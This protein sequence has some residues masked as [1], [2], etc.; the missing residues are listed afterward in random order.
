LLTVTSGATATGTTINGGGSQ[1]VF[2]GGVTTGTTI[3]SGGMEV[4]AAGASAL[5]VTQLVGGV[6]SAIVGLDSAGSLVTGSNESGNFSISGLT[7]SGVILNSGG[8]LSISSGGIASATVVNNAG[9]IY[10]SSGGASYYTQISSGGNEHILSGGYGPSSTIFAGGA[11]TIDSGGVDLGS[12]IQAGG[13]QVVAGIAQAA[14]ISGTQ[15]ILAGGSGVGGFVASGG[16]VSAESGSYISDYAISGASASII[17]LGSVNASLVGGAAISVS[18]SANAVTLN[19]ASLSAGIQLAGVGNTLAL[20]NGTTVVAGVSLVDSSN[21][22][23]LA[24][25]NQSLVIAG[26]STSGAITVA[27]WN[28]LNLTNSASAA[29]AGDLA[30]AGTSSLLSIDGTSLLSQATNSAIVVANSVRNA[31]TI[32][33]GTG[34]TLNIVG[35]YEQTGTLQAGISSPNSYGKMAVNGAAALSNATYSIAANSQIALGAR[36]RNV[37]SATGGTA[38]T[39]GPG[40]YRGIAYSFVV[41]GIG[42][43][44]VT[45]ATPVSSTTPTPLLNGGQSAAVLNQAQAT[46]QIVRERMEKMT[47][48]AHQE[49]DSNNYF[50]ATPYGFTARQSANGVPS[51]AYNQNTGGFAMGADAPIN[52]DLRV[53]GALILQSSSLTGQDTQTQNGLNATSYQLAAYARQ[54]VADATEVNVIANLALDQNSSTRLDT[55]G[56][57]ETATASF[58]GWH[59][60]VSSELAHQV[61]VGQSTITP[62]ARIDYGYVR[63]GAYNENGAGISN[64]A[65]NSQTQSSA[66]GSVGVRYRYDINESSR[67]LVKATGGHDFAAKAASLTATD[68]AGTTFTSYG[69]NPGSFVMQGGVGYE[70]QT[71]DNIRI[72]VN[73]DY[74]G[75]SGYSNNMINA[76]VRIP[77]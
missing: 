16:T 45:A 61:A 58:K 54:K 42:L 5:G 10:V 32:V 2:T 73:Y 39:F 57:P 29:L 77:F 12:T 11:Q 25:S 49:A 71:K 14:S 22:N 64:L 23:F 17:A 13:R 8:S 3:N 33:V 47:G 35:N 34:Q 60:L 63:V 53:G 40:V 56:G 70:M 59:G 4:V 69:N 38:G 27:G 1:F 75:R 6:L 28:Q 36:Y 65:V 74:L 26:T 50:W 48:P 66:I 67:I 41:D 21:A 46:I 30:L 76:G 68:G 15:T 62:L 55:I 43:D 9:A 31:G 52:P 19:G 7:A 37:F 20:Q 24:L 72:R 51:G 44:L 18:G